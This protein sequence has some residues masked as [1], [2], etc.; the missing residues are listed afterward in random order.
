MSVTRILCNR[1]EKPLVYCDC[2]TLRVTPTE[3]PKESNNTMDFSQPPVMHVTNTTNYTP[4]AP[5]KRG[6][7][8]FF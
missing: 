4:P 5:K 3:P 6:R 7:S 2:R 8:K 1:C